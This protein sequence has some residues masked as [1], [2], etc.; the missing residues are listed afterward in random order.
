MLRG[1]AKT[2]LFRA[3]P[4]A[5]YHRARNR[6][7]L[8]VIMFH[9][10]LDRGDRRWAYCDPEYT[11]AGDLF[12]QCL[13]FF[14][15]HYHVVSIDD[16]L[17]PDAH[18]PDHPLLITFDDGWADHEQ[19]ALPLLANAGLPALVFV[20][21]DAVDAHEPERF[22]EIRLVH[23][24]R[25]G[26]LDRRALTGLW[27]AATTAPAPAFDRLDDVRALIERMIALDL[28]RVAALLAPHA[29]A[30]ATPGDRHMLTTAEL[31]NLPR[32]RVAIGGH[33][34]SHAPMTRLADPAADLRRSHAELAAR[35]GAPVPT[36]SFPH[37]AYRRDVVDAARAA[38]YRVVFTSDP[39]LNPLPDG[40]PMPTLLGRVAFDPAAI[41]DHSG[42]FRPELLAFHLWRKG[43]H[44]LT[45]EPRRASAFD[46][47][48]DAA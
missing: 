36:M 40:G 37:G 28:D 42:A 22:W 17:A 48:A 14:T 45:G 27:S 46:R 9:R 30:L 12:A 33:G 44:A 47:R 5:A 11:I 18:L 3:G 24:Y 31:L 41:V 34:A 39:V 23:A 2:A 6:R 16:V 1:L 15:A 38:G 25:R 10:V 32:N 35:L 8:T 29:G 19:V 20:A 13:A 4:L 21:A 7:V 26:A 43:H